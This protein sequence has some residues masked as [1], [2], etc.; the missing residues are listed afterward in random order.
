MRGG[1]VHAAVGTVELVEDDGCIVGCYC[2][3]FF[4]GKVADLNAAV[5]GNAVSDVRECVAILACLGSYPRI[6]R[7]CSVFLVF[8]FIVVVIYP[9]AVV[10]L[11]VFAGK[12]ACGSVARVSTVGIRLLGMS[13]KHTA[14][15]ECIPLVCGYDVVVDIHL[16]SGDNVLHLNGCIAPLT[17]D[18]T[19]HSAAEGSPKS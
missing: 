10:D 12:E 14:S 2:R 1:S 18:N 13:D 7:T 8:K 5:G 3:E 16:C 11:D 19:A 4:L 9:I 17:A 15:A 6:S